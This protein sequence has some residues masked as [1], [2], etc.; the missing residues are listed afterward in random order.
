MLDNAGD[1]ID[2]YVQV[3]MDK[4]SSEGELYMG[5]VDL[6]TGHVKVNSKVFTS[7]ISVFM[8][9]TSQLIKTCFKLT[10]PSAYKYDGKLTKEQLFAAYADAVKWAREAMK[11]NKALVATFE[12]QQLDSADQYLLLTY[13]ILDKLN[14]DQGLNSIEFRAAASH[15]DLN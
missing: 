15:H 10:T 11:D 1:K 3:V 5:V 6:M 9:P 7:T 4:I 14:A 8:D 13:L 12:S 2:E